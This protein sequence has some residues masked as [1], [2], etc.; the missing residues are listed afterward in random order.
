MSSVETR[1]RLPWQAGQ[2]NC[3]RMGCGIGPEVSFARAG[4]GALFGFEE[5]DIQAASRYW[6]V[7]SEAGS[8]SASELVLLP[9]P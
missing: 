5:E 3:A 9:D 6:M 1:A 2:A 7:A 4:S 8:E